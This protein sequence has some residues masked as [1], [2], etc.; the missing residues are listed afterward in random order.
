MT[1]DTGEKLCTSQKKD[2]HK[3]LISS[4]NARF[5]V[6][7]LL[8]TFRQGTKKELAGE[9]QENAMAIAKTY[10]PLGKLFL[11]SIIQN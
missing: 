5:F 10:Y 8:T 7:N 9:Q 4:Q 6:N 1:D 3:S 2:F 11:A